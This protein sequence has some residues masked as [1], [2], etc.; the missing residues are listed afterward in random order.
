MPIFYRAICAEDVTNKPLSDKKNCECNFL[1]QFLE[2]NTFSEWRIIMD[3]KS[4]KSYFEKQE[5]KAFRESFINKKFFDDFMIIGILRKYDVKPDCSLYELVRDASSCIFNLLFSQYKIPYLRMP[6]PI[7][8]PLKWEDRVF[9]QYLLE[10]KMLGKKQGH[11]LDRNENC[12]PIDVLLFICKLDDGDSA[13]PDVLEMLY[14]AFAYLYERNLDPV[15]KKYIRTMYEAHTKLCREESDYE[16]QENIIDKASFM[17]KNI[18]KER[19]STNLKEKNFSTLFDRLLDTLLSEITTTCIR[20]FFLYSTDNTTTY[21]KLVEDCLVADDSSEYQKF[22]EREADT[23]RSHINQYIHSIDEEKQFYQSQRGPGHIQKQY[24]LPQYEK[25]E[26]GLI[27]LLYE[28]RKVKMKTDSEGKKRSMSEFSPEEIDILHHRINSK[29]AEKLPFNL[30]IAELHTAY[31]NYNNYIVNQSAVPLTKD[32]TEISKQL[33]EFHKLID[34]FFMK[35]HENDWCNKTGIFYAPWDFIQT[36]ACTWQ[37]IQEYRPHLD[38]KELDDLA[39]IFK[40]YCKK[41]SKLNHPKTQ[42]LLL[43]NPIFFES[44]LEAPHWIQDLEFVIKI[45]SDISSYALRYICNISDSPFSHKLEELS[46]LEG[47]LKQEY[48]YTPP[49]EK[50]TPEMLAEFLE[51]Y[52]PKKVSRTKSKKGGQLNE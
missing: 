13:T 14:Y 49:R 31:K 5:D 19:L 24:T 10:T 25:E 50:A 11:Y 40:F 26:Y 2:Q 7:S 33:I 39:E 15:E 52:L 44:C 35:H 34:S 20:R 23:L 21:S 9:L 4:M 42:L 12:D 41:I 27:Y 22:V 17:L 29:L 38:S 36:A 16:V 3:M 46:D 8:S 48:V 37:R 45:I 51:F 47:V 1:L 32:L 30:S 43:E 18:A 6:Y 28:R